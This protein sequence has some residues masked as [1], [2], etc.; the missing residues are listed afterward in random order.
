VA[1]VPVAV[2]VAARTRLTAER[3]K[4][5][6]DPCHR[7]F[8]PCRPG[9]CLAGCPASVLLP[10]TDE[11]PVPPC[12]HLTAERPKAA[13]NPRH[14]V[15]LVDR[16]PWT[17]PWIRHP[18]GPPLGARRYS[19]GRSWVTAG[20]G[21]RRW[22]SRGGPAAL[23]PSTTSTT[24]TTSTSVV[25]TVSRVRSRGRRP[26][27]RCLA[28]QASRLKDL[29]VEQRCSFVRAVVQDSQARV[30]DGTVRGLSPPR[31]RTSPRARDACLRPTSPGQG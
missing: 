15:L 29:G 4:A 24:P 11:I 7:G 18:G 13:G 26:G 9:L 2:L 23:R 12:T 28:G 6:D 10:V 17:A 14:V 27:S 5:A 21:Q 30:A 25:Q 20:I 31:P 1:P 22:C 19:H 16:C 8:P 3:P